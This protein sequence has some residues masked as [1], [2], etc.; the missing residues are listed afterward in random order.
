[1]ENNNELKELISTFKEYRELITPIEQNLKIFSASFESIK[2]DLDSLSAG[3]DGSLQEKLDKISKELS[4][5]AEKSKTLASDVEKFMNSTSQ[6]VSSVDRLISVCGK[7]ESKLSLVD[8]LESKA[9]QQIKKLDVIIEEKKKSYDIR[10]LEKNLETYNVGVE[11]VSQY[12]N[13]DVVDTLQAN[14]EKIG[15][16]QEKNKQI[17][18]MLNDE[19]VS[20]DKL[21]ET[22]EASN[23]LLRKVVEGKDVNEQYI[24]EILDRWAED[25]KYKKKK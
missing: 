20:V 3:F 15:Q 7:I 12:I 14:N 5:Q 23:E 1:M 8:N 4:M 2:Q 25:R 24:Y 6:Y 11:K 16:I 19:K 17:S 21:L 18:E 22:F 9:E 10:Q 13:K